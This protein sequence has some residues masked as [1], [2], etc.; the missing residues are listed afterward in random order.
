MEGYGGR[1]RLT[2]ERPLSAL[3]LGGVSTI[4]LVHFLSGMQRCSVHVYL[5]T[6]DLGGGSEVLVS[7]VTEWEGR[8]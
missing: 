2:G 5:P 8:S 6:E 1:K 3:P 7:E 4:G